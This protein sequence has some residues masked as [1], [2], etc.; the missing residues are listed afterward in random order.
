MIEQRAPHGRCTRQLQT[1]YKIF[2]ILEKETQNWHSSW[3]QMIRSLDFFIYLQV[4]RARLPHHAAEYFVF[5]G[6]DSVTL[7]QHLQCQ[8]QCRIQQQDC[9]SQVSCRKGIHDL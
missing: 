6:M 7:E 4:L 5:E 8:C 1:T 3:M 2:L 9:L